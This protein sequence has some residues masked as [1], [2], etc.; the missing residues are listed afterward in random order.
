MSVNDKKIAM[1]ALNGFPPSY[2]SLIRALDALRNDDD[3]VTFDLVKSRLLQEEQRASE[4]DDINS[5]LLGSSALIGISQVDKDGYTNLSTYRCKNCNNMGYTE[6]HCWGMD[7]DRKGPPRPANGN[8]Q[9]QRKKQ[10]ASVNETQAHNGPSVCSADYVCLKYRIKDL[11]VPSAGSFWI[12]E[13]CCTTHITFDMLLF[14]T[15]NLIFLTIVEMGTKQ[16]VAA[17]WI[18]DILFNLKCDSSFS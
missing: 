11:N 1:A 10:D 6:A 18:G 5:K 7:M 8:R 4:R 17:A 14:L 13:S 16:T 9:G 15:Y 2:R 12:N 3:M